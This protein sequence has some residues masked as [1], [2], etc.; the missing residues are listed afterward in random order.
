VAEHDI[1]AIVNYHG[2]RSKM[3]ADRIVAEYDRIIELLV[4][5]PYVV[6]ER[7]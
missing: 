6:A 3:K 1:P 4:V 5:N 7:S 2:P